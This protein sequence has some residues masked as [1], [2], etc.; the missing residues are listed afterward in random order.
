MLHF[1]IIL[2]H[3]GMEFQILVLKNKQ[4]FTQYISMENMIS[5]LCM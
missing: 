2:V 1:F 3:F 4:K 5:F